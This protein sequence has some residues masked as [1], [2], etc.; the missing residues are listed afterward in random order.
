MKVIKRWLSAKQVGQQ[1]AY[2][3]SDF[4]SLS[5]TVFTYKMDV[6][7]LCGSLGHWNTI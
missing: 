1:T 6:T 5:F 4:A 3:L 2:L 7:S